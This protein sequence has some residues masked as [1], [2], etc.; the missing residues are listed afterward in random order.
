[1]QRLA[2]PFVVALALSACQSGTAPEPVGAGSTPPAATS[3]GVVPEP[4]PA[5]TPAH[6]PRRI[7]GGD[8]AD[9]RLVDV[10]TGRHPTYERIVFEF[11][12]ARGALEVIPRFELRRIDPPITEAG[13]GAEIAVDG[14]LFYSIVFHGASGA[15][16]RGENVHL[17]YEGPEEIKPDGAEV[18]VEAEQTGDFEATLS[19]AFGLSRP[20]CPTV[21]TL[22]N[23]ARVVLDW[24]LEPTGD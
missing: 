24:P 14:A 18:L 20:S 5:P 23:P 17:T 10:R 1:M 6:C 9:V 8:D 21:L 16:L 4:T 13:S 7:T 15:E 2:V 3:E 19:W 11:R 12:P 22:L